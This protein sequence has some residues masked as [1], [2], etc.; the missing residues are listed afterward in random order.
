MACERETLIDAYVDGELDAAHAAE[1]S[2]HLATCARCAAFERDALDLR[3]RIRREATRHAAPPALR[4]RVLDVTGNEQP[5]GSP[6]R[7]WRIGR[8]SRAWSAL[9]A[10]L[11]IGI[12]L[13]QAPGLWRAPAD[14]GPAMA[15]QVLSAHLRA[16]RPNH[17]L[18]V[19]STDRHT[20][21]PWFDGQVS[22]APPVKDLAGDGFP[23]LGGR[24]DVVGLRPVAAMVYG[25]RLHRI[26][27][28]V[29]PDGGGEPAPRAFALDGY[30]VR[31]W[32]EGGFTLWA[33]SDLA[34]A[35][36]DEFAARW[37]AAS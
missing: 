11:L 20:V 2:A 33:C 7:P 9:A 4:R 8:R 37:R 5:A 15:E 21:K 22:F 34:G 28:F 36:L 3:Q 27:L 12:V 17:L 24:L 13:G 19:V 25:R 23:L 31:T 1:T 30:N 14:P 16:L 18:D 29:W 26:S 35:E 32:Q 10:A 6:V